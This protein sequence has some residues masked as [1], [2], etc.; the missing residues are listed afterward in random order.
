[1]PPHLFFPQCRGKEVLRDSLIG[2]VRGEIA[3]GNLIKKLKGRNE[4]YLAEEHMREGQ[5]VV[6]LRDHIRDHALGDAPTRRVAD[7]LGAGD[8]CSGVRKGHVHAN[9][10]VFFPI[11]DEL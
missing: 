9:D 10:L 5:Q 8:T 4:E 7:E 6:L 2:L 3:T 11:D 1:M